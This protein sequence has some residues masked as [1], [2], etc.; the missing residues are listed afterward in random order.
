MF[1]AQYILKLPE[2]CF[3]SLP[4]CLIV[5]FD[6]ILLPLAL[7]SLTTLN[8]PFLLIVRIASEDNFKVIHLSS[9]ARKYLLVC[10]LGRNLL[11]VLIFEWDTVFP[12]M[13]L[14]PVT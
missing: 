12:E 14:L 5:S 6:Q 8:S 9:S 11:L 1:C 13:G 7:I 3:L 10:R 2:P 4:Y